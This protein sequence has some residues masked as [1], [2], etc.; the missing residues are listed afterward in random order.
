M[1]KCIVSFSS[2]GRENYNAAMLRLIKSTKEAGW[3]GGYLLRSLDGYCD[4]YM[5]VPIALGSYPVTKE[6]GQSFNHAEAPYQFKTYLIQEAIEKG[7]DVVVWC[8]STVR[9]V[10]D[11]TPLLDIAAERGVAAFDNLGFPLRDWLTDIA[12]E[13]VGISDEELG[14]AKQIM[15]CVVIFDLRTEKGK[16]IFNRW[17]E[18]SRDGVSFQN[19]YTSKRPGF[20][21]TRHDQSCLSA[22]LHTEGVELLP[23]G[24]LCYPPHDKTKEYGEDIYFINKGVD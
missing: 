4:N 11:I 7:Y 9:M 18:L 3:D 23:Y 14:H 12:Q 8:D 2:M 24:R 17:F 6:H 10:K 13:H 5:G 21:S 1:K 22:I 19:G 15:A 20:R 16:K